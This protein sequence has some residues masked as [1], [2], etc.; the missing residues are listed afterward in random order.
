MPTY[1]SLVGVWLIFSFLDFHVESYFAD[2]KEIPM[3]KYTLGLVRSENNRLQL[4]Y[5]RPLQD[6]SKRLEED[7]QESLALITNVVEIFNIDINLRLQVLMWRSQVLSLA[8]AVLSLAIAV[9]A[10]FK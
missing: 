6:L 4:F 10:I 2:T 8:I 5:V 7:I 3:I 1:R 9:L